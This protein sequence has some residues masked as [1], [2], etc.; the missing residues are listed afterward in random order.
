VIARKVM[1]ISAR[2]SSRIARHRH[3]ERRFSFFP[4]RRD[5]ETLLQNASQPLTPPR[6]RAGHLRRYGAITAREAQR[7]SVESLRRALTRRAARTTSPSTSD[8][9]FA[10]ALVRWEHLTAGPAG[11]RFVEGWAQPTADRRLGPARGVR[12]SGAGR[13]DLVVSVNLPAR[14]RSKVTA[15]SGPVL[16]EADLAPP[17]STRDHR[18]GAIRRRASVRQPSNPR[19]VGVRDDFGTATRPQLPEAPAADGEARSPFATW[20]RP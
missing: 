5:A 13:Q 1:V 11:G 16:R 7:L 12:R 4:R 15:E 20:S 19:R 8:A 2:S 6:R 18:G 3:G 10:E 14:T 9:S 17:P